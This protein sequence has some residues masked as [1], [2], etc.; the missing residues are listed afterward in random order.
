MSESVLHLTVFCIHLLILMLMVLSIINSSSCFVAN[1]IR[2]YDAEYLTFVLC[3]YVCW[4][5]K[6]YSS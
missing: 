6:R 3:K 1:R 5:L 2:F 4:L